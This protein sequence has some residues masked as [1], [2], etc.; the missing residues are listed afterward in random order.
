MHVALAMYAFPSHDFF[1]GKSMFIYCS[2]IHFCLVNFHAKLFVE[3]DF[4]LNSIVPN[5][6]TRLL[7]YISI[8]HVNIHTCMN[9]AS[10]K[11]WQSKMTIMAIV[12]SHLLQRMVTSAK[13][14]MYFFL[15]VL[16]VLATKQ[17]Q[18]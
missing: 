5:C 13:I 11:R 1:K 2:H 12:Q 15:L 4:H 7:L 3:E 6:C 18:T 10:L 8:V 9:A 14:N 16:N 17:W